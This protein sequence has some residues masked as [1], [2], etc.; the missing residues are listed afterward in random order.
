MRAGGISYKP[1]SDT[2]L[3]L[4]STTPARSQCKSKNNR[5]GHGVWLSPRML[6]S[7]DGAMRCRSVLRCFRATWGVSEVCQE[8]VNPAEPRS[9]SRKSHSCSSMQVRGSLVAHSPAGFSS[10]NSDEPRARAWLSLPIWPA[11]HP[12]AAFDPR[13]PRRAEQSGSMCC[14]P[15]VAVGCLSHRK[16]TAHAQLRDRWSKPSATIQRGFFAEGSRNFS[17]ACGSTI[18]AGQHDEWARREAS[19]FRRGLTQ[20]MGR[21]VFAAGRDFI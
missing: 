21:F 11:S 5:L 2:S 20:H 13:S 17:L 9:E 18:S 10:G 19:G 8:A 3:F 4:P 1:V 6:W 15:K 14:I 7:H 16:V 12:R